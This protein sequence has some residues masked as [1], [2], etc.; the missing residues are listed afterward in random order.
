MLSYLG[1]P[2]EKYGYGGD[3]EI[4]RKYTTM[5]IPT[6]RTEQLVHAFSLHKYQDI[7]LLITYPT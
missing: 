2:V 7:Q 6:D 5:C 1:H 3:G 4:S